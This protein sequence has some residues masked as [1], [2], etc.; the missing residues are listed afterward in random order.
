MSLSLVV[1]VVI[2]VAVV[3]ISWWLQQKTAQPRP[4]PSSP[5]LDFPPTDSAFSHEIEQEIQR[6]ILNGE[7]ISAIRLIRKQTGWGL[8]VSKEYVEALC[9]GR[10]QLG[11]LHQLAGEDSIAPDLRNELKQLLAEGQKL[12]AIKLLRSE[13][14]MDLK[15]AKEYVEALALQDLS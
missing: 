2:I 1:L 12:E 5:R 7:K 8:K 6:L 14:G 10:I 13:S 9:Q 11:A 4:R 3:W 15:A